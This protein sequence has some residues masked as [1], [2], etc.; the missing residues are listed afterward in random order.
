MTWRMAA[1]G[2]ARMAPTMPA[3]LPPMRS[4]MMT[5][6]A[7][8]PTWRDMILGTR[9]WFSSCCCS[10]KKMRTSSA[11][12]GDTEAATA[13]AGMAERIGPMTGIISPIAEMSART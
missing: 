7:L 13:S 4:A 8:T 2:T 9:T 12:C 3:R 11:Y 1:V 6:T 10:T 5:V